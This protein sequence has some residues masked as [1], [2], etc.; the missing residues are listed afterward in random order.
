[1]PTR[2]AGPDQPNEGDE[3]EPLALELHSVAIHLLR[4]IRVTDRSLAVTPARLSALSVLVFG[5]PRT[6][7]QLAQAEQ[8][9]GPTMSRIVAALEQDGLVRRD[10]D[11][12][13]RRAVR[14]SA[15][16]AGRRL[17]LR[18]RRRRVERL[19]AELRDLPPEDRTTLRTAVAILRD[20][21]HRAADTRPAPARKAGKARNAA[22]KAPD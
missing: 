11:P 20:L 8:V 4:R 16:P 2:S 13:D 14:L 12:G 7:T 15:T 3:L 21:E 1:V 22:P 18:G 10:P 6:L 9:T 17:M 19:V 5:G